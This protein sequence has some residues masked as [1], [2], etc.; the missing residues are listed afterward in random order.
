LISK[1]RTTLVIE[2]RLSTASD[3]DEIL[4]LEEGQITERGTHEELLMKQGK[5]SEMWNKQK[6]TQLA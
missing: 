1:N 3:A 5:Y 6:D 2:H 4:V